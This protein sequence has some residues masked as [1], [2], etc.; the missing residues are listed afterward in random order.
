MNRRRNPQAA[1]LHDHD[2]WEA[3]WYA[4]SVALLFVALWVPQWIW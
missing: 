2:R 3:R 4:I 1:V